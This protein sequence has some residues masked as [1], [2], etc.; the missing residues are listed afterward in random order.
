MRGQTGML[1]SVT[2]LDVIKTVGL[3]VPLI[4]G[5]TLVGDVSLV[6][7]G[8]AMLSG[9]GILAG[10]CGG[11]LLGVCALPACQ[12]MLASRGW[13]AGVAVSIVASVLGGILYGVDMTIL[14]TMPIPAQIKGLFYADANNPKFQSWSSL[15]I[16]YTLFGALASVFGLV[17]AILYEKS[18][19]QR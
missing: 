11:L 1:R 4:A 3:A 9:W 5:V 19:N 16:G 13:R 10:L 7:E 6:H 17:Y 8:D 12:L 15:L 14:A 2:R 18:R